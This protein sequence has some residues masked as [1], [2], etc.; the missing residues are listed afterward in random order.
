MAL[1]STFRRMTKP[2][3][4]L[5]GDWL[6]LV[7]T[8]HGEPR[9]NDVAA[10]FRRVAPAVCMH[11]GRELKITAVGDGQIPSVELVLTRPLTYLAQRL[12]VAFELYYA[13]HLPAAE[14]C[15]DSDIIIVMRAVD[16]GTLNF[17]REAREGSGAAVIYIVD[18][19]F[20][21]IDAQSPLGRR[22]IQL[23]AKENERALAML[24]DCVLVF[25]EAMRNKFKPLAR[26][27]RLAPSTA[28]LESFSTGLG[29]APE[30][31]AP[32]EVRIGFAGSSTHAS[33]VKIVVPAL[34]DILAEYGLRLKV[35]TIGQEIEALRDH[36]H[37]R[38]FSSIS[39][40][41][42]F[43][44]FLQL[45]RWDIGLAPLEWN[46]FNLAK[47]NN[48]YRT[49]GGAG[50]AAVYSNLPEFSASVRQLETGWLV[51]NTPEAWRTASRSLVND[52]HLRGTIAKNA[53]ADVLEKYNIR[54]VSFEYRRI[55]EEITGYRA[56]EACGNADRHDDSGFQPS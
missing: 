51:D 41:D 12:N 30:Y 40:L 46:T 26:R 28:G 48:K 43:F 52:P 36:P 18:D 34:L 37:Y 32:D 15:R 2:L 50:I 5:A 33:S 13:D 24:A 14:Q 20:D 35:E 8:G 1:E 31:K 29:S 42:Q 19:D 17:V 44:R 3:R 4:A 11:R 56:S 49:Y 25:T 21:A 38:H 45:R 39:G 27:V 22:L 53:R 55:F 54:V 16:G 10:D 9:R 47:T 6:K 23:N 7:S